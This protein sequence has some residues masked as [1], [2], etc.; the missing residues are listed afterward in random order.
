MT[1]RRILRRLID[2]VTGALAY[3]RRHRRISP[4]PDPVKV[5]A[6]S[7]LAVA[8][9][10]IQLDASFNAFAAGWP[11]PLLRLLWR[12]SDSRRWYG[13]EEYV[14]LLRSHR[15][16]HHQLRYGLPLPDD[17]VDFVYT[18][19]TL[20][21]LPRPVAARF[22]GEARRV[23]RPGGTLRICVPDLDFILGLFESGERERALGYFFL[24]EF[25]GELGR[26][27]WLYDEDSL[28]ELLASQGFADIERRSAGVGRTPDL[29]I[30]DNRPE[31]TLYMEGRAL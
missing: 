19:H 25:E 31:E 12:L 24:E 29:E 16:V 22:V 15:F 6:G 2:S 14:E 11:R 20:E 28:R 21:H 17:S 30:L 4:G 18:S 7:G 13:R 9:G 10:W 8:P 23:L 5:N 27:R 3:L 1:A 26:H